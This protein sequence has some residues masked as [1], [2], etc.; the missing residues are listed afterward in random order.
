MATV[1]LVIGVLAARRFREKFALKAPTREELLEL[2]DRYLAAISTVNMAP[3]AP[4]LRTTEPTRKLRA[5]LETWEF[6]LDVPEPIVRLARA[7]L[8]AN[9]IDEPP[10]GWDDWP[11]PDDAPLRSPSR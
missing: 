1:E 6:S 2:L 10:E 11:G 9:G 7:W 8:A 5:L 3:T 4:A